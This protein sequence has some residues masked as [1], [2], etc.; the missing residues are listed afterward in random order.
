MRAGAIERSEMLLSFYQGIQSGLEKVGGEIPLANEF[1]D[2]L[3]G[4]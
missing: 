3:A 1:L 2:G 4:D